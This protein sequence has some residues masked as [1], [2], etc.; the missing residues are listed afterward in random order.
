MLVK[1][2]LNDIKKQSSIE[3]LL[4]YRSKFLQIYDYTNTEDKM[5]A[6]HAKILVVDNSKI[7]DTQYNILKG[8]NINED[9]NAPEDV[10]T[11]DLK[12]MIEKYLM[13]FH[14]QKQKLNSN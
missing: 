6:L 11:E 13:S 14:I 10:K 3:K 2:Y 5:A 9:L 8:V 1:L 12:D 7:F 4:R